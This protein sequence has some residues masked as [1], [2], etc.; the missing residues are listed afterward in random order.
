MYV[1]LP[2]TYHKVTTDVSQ[3]ERLVGGGG[4][5]GGNIVYLWNIKFVIFDRP[6]MKYVQAK[7]YL[8]GHLN[9]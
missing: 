3:W 1:K 9:R 8:P 6:E 7:M 5:G 2:L 4:G